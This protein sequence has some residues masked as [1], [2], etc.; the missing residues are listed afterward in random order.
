MKAIPTINIIQHNTNHWKTNKTNLVN[1][2]LQINPDIIHTQS[3]YIAGYNIYT[4]NTF[5]EMHDGSV[6]LVKSSIKLTVIDD[7]IT[8]MIELKQQTTVGIISIA[9]TY[10]P[11]RRPYLP[12][13]DFHRL[14][15]NNHPTYYNKKF[16]RKTH[17]SGTKETFIET[18]I[19]H[20]EPVHLGPNFSTYFTQKTCSTPD[21]ILSNNKA[22]HII[23][24]KPDR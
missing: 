13:P 12:F 14:L 18:F 15:Y 9:T 4:K 2:Y 3:L 22:T 21:I 5:G 19:E 23:I 6:I 20:G 1:T 11:L 8:D 10:L 16:V 17:S 7:F 24:K